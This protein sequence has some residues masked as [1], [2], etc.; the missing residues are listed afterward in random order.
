MQ[1]S[2]QVPF[3]FFFYLSLASLCIFLLSGCSGS[4]H[5]VSPN[6]LNSGVLT[7]TQVNSDLEG[8][9]PVNGLP[10]GIRTSEDEPEYIEGELLVVLHDTCVDSDALAL[11]Q[12]Q[13]VRLSRTLPLSWGTIYKVEITDGTPV[14]EITERLK[15]DPRVK[16]NFLRGLPIGRMGVSED[17]KGLALLLGSD[18]SSFIT[19]ALIPLDGGNLAKNPG[20]SHPGM[21]ELEV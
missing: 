4:S 17:I 21:P 10:C 13:P 7:D 18:A 12:S 3:I 5:P 16:K 8:Q 20:G 1:Y 2:R 15:A 6:L 14:E 9:A 11:L 19:G